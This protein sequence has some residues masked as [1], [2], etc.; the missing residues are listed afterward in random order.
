MKGG[1]SPIDEWK[2]QNPGKDAG[3]PTVQEIA[4]ACDNP[5]KEP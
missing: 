1:K 5:A 2:K 3:D 4:E